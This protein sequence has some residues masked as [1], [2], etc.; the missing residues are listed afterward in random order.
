MTSFYVQQLIILAEELENKLNETYVIPGRADYNTKF[1]AQRERLAK[2]HEFFSRTLRTI[3]GQMESDIGT[4]KAR[5][6]DPNMRRH[7]VTVYRDLEK[8]FK[9]INPEKPYIAAQKLVDYVAD[10]H[11]RSV[12]DNLEFLANH[13]LESTKPEAVGPLPKNVSMIVAITSLEMLKTLAQK[14]KYHM[15]QFPLIEVQLP[16][17]VPPPRLVPAVEHPAQ[18]IS[19]EQATNPAIPKP[20][21]NV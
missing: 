15:D 5:D 10:R 17:T 9:E 8:I 3:L 7:M 2:F 16:S 21:L 1:H 14:L 13:H 6:F 11:H 19:G 20:K 12:I 18:P 4:L